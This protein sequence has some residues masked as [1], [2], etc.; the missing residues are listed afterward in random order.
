MKTNMGESMKIKLSPWL[1]LSLILGGCAAHSAHNPPAIDQKQTES[2]PL[3]T[4]QTDGIVMTKLEPPAL[5]ADLASHPNFATQGFIIARESYKNTNDHPVKI[6]PAK[7]DGS[8]SLQTQVRSTITA[9][10]NTYLYVTSLALS[11]TTPQ[12]SFDIEQVSNSVLNQPVVLAPNQEIILNWR[13]FP[14]PSL[15]PCAVHLG[16]NRWN[17]TDIVDSVDGANIT[18]G[19][20]R[21]V[22]FSDDSNQIQGDIFSEPLSPNQIVG[23]VNTTLNANLDCVW[24]DFVNSAPEDY[25][26]SL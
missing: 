9:G 1:G 21:K 5:P 15:H 19:F 2:S 16:L 13:I 6:I 17:H 24:T 3:P 12:S 8:A 7:S 4:S 14:A 10:S 20:Q 18:G 25:D 26:I 11:V 22:S 23:T